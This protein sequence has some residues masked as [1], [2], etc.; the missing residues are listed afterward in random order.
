MRSTAALRL[1][2][3]VSSRAHRYKLV[4][5]RPRRYSTRRPHILTGLRPSIH[6]FSPLKNLDTLQP[7]TYR[8]K[9]SDTELDA[10]AAAEVYAAEALAGLQATLL[11][12]T[13]TQSRARELTQNIHE[14]KE[15]MTAAAASAT[16]ASSKRS[17]E[18]P[19]LIAVSKLKPAIDILA[20]HIDGQEH[21]G[22]NYVQELSKKQPILPNT[23]H[24]HFIGSLQSSAISKLARLPNLYAV[25]S[26]DSAKKAVA[27]NRLRPDNLP[28]VRVFI[29][30]NTSGE[31]SKSGLAPSSEDLYTAV[32]TIRKEC[33][34]LILEGLMT[35]GAIARS[36]AAK[37]GEENEDFITLVNVAEELE[38]RIEKDD[39]EKVTLKLSMGMSDDFENAIA[40]GADYV[41]VGSSIF[42]A[43]PAKAD[44][45]IL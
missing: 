27:L 25:H 4:A 9:M 3:L 7:H 44:A 38:A 41:R 42:G 10:A 16:A 26:V 22:E 8:S 2:N 40:L 23:I 15:R 30:V 13:E 34:K 19:L 5:I 28:P 17:N 39:G 35:I 32:A 1:R 36:Q 11:N 45:T 24:W 20:L 12:D 18:G 6:P 14:I 43:R 21:F 33:P 29:Q 31:D 37:E